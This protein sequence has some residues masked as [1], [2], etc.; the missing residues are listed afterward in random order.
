MRA[1]GRSGALQGRS[2]ARGAWKPTGGARGGRSGGG[3][4]VGRQGGTG[5][6][7]RENGEGVVAAK[8][9]LALPA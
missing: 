3:V 8:V 5:R 2:I 7:G 9:S 1:D 4:T 6:G